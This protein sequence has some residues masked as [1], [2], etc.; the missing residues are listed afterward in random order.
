MKISYSFKKKC[1]S[2]LA[3]LFLISFYANSQIVINEGSNRNYSTIAD[4]DGEFPDWIEIFNQSE[5]TVNLYN[6]SLSDDINNNLKWIF[7][8]IDIPPLEFK[9]IYC[10][11]KNRKPIDS[12]ENVDYVTNYTPVT[13]WNTHTLNQPFYWDG[14]SNLLINICAYNSYQYT[15]NSVFNQTATDYYSTLYA[16]QD[17]SDAICAT[18]YGTKVMQRPNIKLNNAIIGTG[19][20]QNGNTDYPAPYGNWYWAAKHQMLITAAELTAAGLSEGNITSISFDVVSTDPNTIY[21]YIDIYFKLVNETEL[22]NEFIPLDVNMNQHTNFGID[23]GGETVYLFSPAQNI[24]SQLF[25]N[26]QNL[27]V[28]VGSFPDASANIVSFGTP[29]P[30]ATNNESQAFNSFLQAPV[31]SIPSGIYNSNLGVT[32]QNPNT[33]S[34]IVTY[35]LDGN[36]PTINS[37][38]Y[39]GVNIVINSSH[40]LK[41]KAFSNDALPSPLAASSYLLGIEHTTPIVSVI[42]DVSNLYGDNGIFDHWDQD[43]EKAAYAEYFDT[44]QNLIFSQVAGM[45]IDGGAGGSRSHPQHSFRLEF[46]HSVLGSTPVEYPLI[47]NR[48]ERTTYSKFYLRNGSNQYLTIPYKDATLVTALGGNVK[49]FYSSMEP[50]SVYI[51]GEYFGLYELR[52]KIDNEYF[53]QYENAN[54]DSM[55]ILTL[56]YWYGLVLRA[57]TGSTE[58]FYDAYNNFLNLNPAEETFWDDADQYFDMDY[59]VDYIIAESYAGNRDWPY[60]NIKIYSSDKTNHS[61]RFGIVDLEWSLQPN[62]WASSSDD[63]ISFLF[64]TDQNIPYINIWHKGIQNEKFKN[65]FIN[66]F[67][68]LMNTEYNID[69]ILGVENE[70][71]NKMLPEMP[72]EYARWGDPNQ[73]DAFIENHNVFQSEFIARTDYVREYINT[74]F[75]LD[76]QVEVTLNTIPEG[77]GKIKISTIIQDN[78]PWTGIYFKGNPVT[79]TAM[80]SPGYEF[81]YWQANPVIGGQ[82]YEQSLNLEIF[83]SAEFTAVFAESR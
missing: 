66:R 59:Y 56:S 21:S 19:T 35:T 25:V 40:V 74:G 70:Y 61:F 22:S 28:S 8:N 12:F 80:P 60:N 45:Q 5:D 2:A 48:P 43:W 30:L 14:V 37:T 73:I 27:D 78:L 29:T 10:S 77:S 4:E 75:G 72:N 32:I 9:T 69:K 42:T 71:Y 26:C 65:F 16:A 79:I 36:D 67:A 58:L 83:T 47:S 52:E 63:P 68:D 13:N 82:N 34:S 3:I 24:L 18:S 7:P 76:G 57:T 62:G 81:A 44:S 11:G 64:Q 23:N 15:T 53:E 6:Y 1:I 49:T 31:F 46:A 55:D 38:V 20:I 54:S 41:A 17:G 50:V 51:N 33:V 39:N